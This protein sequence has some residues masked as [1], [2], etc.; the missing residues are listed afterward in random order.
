MSQWDAFTMS[1]WDAYTLKTVKSTY[2]TQRMH[3]RLKSF[4]PMFRIVPLIRPN[5]RALNHSYTLTA[6]F[7]ISPTKKT[8]R[9]QAQCVS[10]SS[11]QDDNHSHGLVDTVS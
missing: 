1:Q 4:I 8:D 11:R 6:H 10:Q 3:A 9:L 2:Y 5:R 7:L